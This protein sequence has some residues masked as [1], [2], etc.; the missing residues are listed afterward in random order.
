MA[1]AFEYFPDETVIEV[2]SNL[3]LKDIYYWCLVSKQFNS[4]ICNNPDFWRRRFITDYGMIEYNGDWKE[5]YQNWLTCWSIGSNMT[6][7]MSGQGSL[8]TVV[9][10]KYPKPKTISSGVQDL[11]LIDLEDNLWILT[12][13]W[14]QEYRIITQVPNFKVRY[15][16]AQRNNNRYSM[17]VGCIIDI[18]DNLWIWGTDAIT[19]AEQFSYITYDFRGL[20][21][22]KLDN[23]NL[24]KFDQRTLYFT[25][26]DDYLW[27]VYF[28][29]IDD[30]YRLGEFGGEKD[31]YSEEE[32][33]DQVESIIRPAMIGDVHIQVSKIKPSGVTAFIT[34]HNELVIEIGTDQFVYATIA[35]Q[36]IIVKDVVMLVYPDVIV[37]DMD[38]NVRYYA[39]DYLG[40]LDTTQ[41]QHVPDYM[42]YITQ[43]KEVDGFGKSLVFLDEK[44]DIV[45]VGQNLK[46]NYPSDEDFNRVMSNIEHFSVPHRIHGFKV[47]EFSVGY[48]DLVMIATRIID[49]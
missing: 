19:V 40:R 42:Q 18:Y 17:D 26:L 41:P 30:E 16:Q 29:D 7:T 10:L 11:L 47:R 9:S 27:Y 33:Y 12:R 25:D 5:L 49:E 6:D 46:S 22:Y 23:V 34:L 28:S 8:N 37:I 35:G 44:A 13:R 32:Y 36:P 48:H 43:A 14:Q 31:Y 24:A 38:N 3:P 45:I 39:Y 4:V 15:V 2:A 21:F 1:D 20:I